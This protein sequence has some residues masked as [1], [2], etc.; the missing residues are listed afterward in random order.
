MAGTSSNL[1]AEEVPE[2]LANPFLVT[3]G[4]T[5]RA[6]GC[7]RD[8]TGRSVFGTTIRQ[9]FENGEMNRT[10][11]DFLGHEKEV[12]SKP[13]L[14]VVPRQATDWAVFDLHQRPVPGIAPRGL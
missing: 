7:I 11:A 12:A 6:R 10:M 4:N 1:D 5:K 3:D 13:L 9:R 14:Y 2:H 8:V